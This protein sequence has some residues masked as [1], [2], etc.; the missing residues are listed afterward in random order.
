MANVVMTLDTY[1]LPDIKDRQG[2]VMK[3]KRVKAI[4]PA[5]HQRRQVGRQ[6]AAVAH[7]RH[8]A[9]ALIAA[10]SG[11]DLGKDLRHPPMEGFA[12]FLAGDRRPASR[13]ALF[14]ELRETL[15]DLGGC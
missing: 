9:L 10:M 14:D 13:P 3:T 12:P 11:D 15:L 4:Q 7:H 6:R 1:P 5:T 2:S 8:L